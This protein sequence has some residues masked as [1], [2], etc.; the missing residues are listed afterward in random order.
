MSKA[1]DTVSHRDLLSTIEQV[2]FRGKT[3]ELFKSYLENR[4]QI[5]VLGGEQ[6]AGRLV[7]CGVPQGTVLGPLL[8]CIYIYSQVE[9]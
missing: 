4:K 5:V 7:T 8:F 6:S 2:G 1:F 9:L 3:L